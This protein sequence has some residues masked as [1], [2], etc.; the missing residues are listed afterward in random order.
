M[1]AMPMLLAALAELQKLV[2]W[3][4]VVLN[5][6][7]SKLQDL[8]TTVKL[9]KEDPGKKTKFG[10]TQVVDIIFRHWISINPTF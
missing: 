4:Q 2:N 1:L 5:N 10:A 8:S 7:H 9:K 3:A 6:L